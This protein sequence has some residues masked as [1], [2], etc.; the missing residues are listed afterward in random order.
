MLKEENMR[1]R[2][3]LLCWLI[4]AGLA[5]AADPEIE[6]EV[7][8]VEISATAPAPA[9]LSWQLDGSKLPAVGEGDGTNILDALEYSGAANLISAPKVRVKSGTNTTIKVVKEIFYPTG[10]EIRR[11]SVT[12]GAAIS[13]VLAI[14]PCNFTNRDVGVTLNVAPVFDAR[15]NMIDLQMTA[16]IVELTEWKEYPAACE[17][18]D[19]TSRA[20]PIAL[21]VFH[22]RRIA[23]N[24]SIRNGSTAVVGSMVTTGTKRVED[25]VPVL[26]A[27]PWLG[28]LFRSSRE[29]SERRQLLITVRARTI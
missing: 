16:E 17:G 3:L 27:I 22:T 1:V 11:E 7:R 12:N 23:P 24:I 4:A 20:V 14:V 28:R 21:P 25:R 19:G 13:S 2:H 18:T 8:F 29:A 5:A 15:R 10:M 6:V 9:G 26:G